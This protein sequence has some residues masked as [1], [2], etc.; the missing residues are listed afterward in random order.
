MFF[1]DN[2]FKLESEQLPNMFRCAVGYQKYVTKK[3]TYNMRVMI[4][5][6]TNSCCRQISIKLWETLSPT[7]CST[8]KVKYESHCSR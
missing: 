7:S 8:L 1:S 4:L 5:Y 6:A 2:V 3:K